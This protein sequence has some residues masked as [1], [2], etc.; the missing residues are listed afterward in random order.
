MDKKHYEVVAAV[1][2]KDNKIYCCQ[3]GNKGECA[4]KWEFPGGKIELG[5]TKEEALVREIKEELN[6]EIKVEKY[7]TTIDHEYNTFSI[8]IHVYLCELI[9]REPTISEH[10]AYKWCDVSELESLD[11]AQADYK[12]LNKIVKIYKAQMDISELKAALNDINLFNK[13]SIEIFE[14][15]LNNSDYQ[16]YIILM[17][18]KNKMNGSKLFKDLDYKT[19]RKVFE[20]IIESIELYIDEE[21]VENRK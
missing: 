5:E 14:K 7:I 12:F 13:K 10:I 16:K 2:V 17:K 8:T 9:D 20:I 3:R 11:F 15:N 6:C 1:I 19:K 18:N 21:I 4:F